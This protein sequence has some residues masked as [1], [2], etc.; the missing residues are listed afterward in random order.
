MK[1]HRSH[2]PQVAEAVALLQR[3]A[4]KRRPRPRGAT[5]DVLGCARCPRCGFEIVARMG[6]TGPMLWCQCAARLPASAEPP[7]AA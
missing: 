1:I 7:T 4:N 3:P 2:A 5:A 6:R